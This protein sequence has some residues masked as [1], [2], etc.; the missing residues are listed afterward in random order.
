MANRIAFEVSSPTSA[1]VTETVVPEAYTNFLLGKKLFVERPLLWHEDAPTLFRKAIELDPDFAP[2]HAYLAICLSLFGLPPERL[3][4]VEAANK[5]A[6]ELASQLAETVFAK[7]LLV[8][9]RDS[10]TQAS[11]ALMRQAIVLDPTLSAAYNILGIELKREGQIAEAHRVH[12]TALNRDPLNPVLITN[13]AWH[14][15]DRGEFDR[16]ERMMMRMTL[17]PEE[18]QF[19]HRHVKTMYHQ[20]GRYDEYIRWS[21]DEVRKAIQRDWK[22]EHRERVPGRLFNV[23]GAHAYAYR[24]IGLRETGLQL[25]ERVAEDHPAHDRRIVWKAELCLAQ[26]NFDC[27]VKLQEGLRN[28]L[29]SDAPSWLSTSIGFAYFFAGDFDRAI[30]NLES[31]LF[32]EEDWQDQLDSSDSFDVVHHLIFALGAQGREKEANQLA[33]EAGSLLDSRMEMMGLRIEPALTQVALSRWLRGDSEGAIE[34]FRSTVDAGWIYLYEARQ[35]PL[36][37]EF[38]QIADFRNELRAVEAEIERQRAVVEAADTT[39]DFSN[40]LDGFLA[41]FDEQT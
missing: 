10:D 15:L 1:E 38:F 36:W 9:W 28:D 7:A 13:V 17:L 5:R 34:A 6:A 35:D 16:G 40:V 8:K 4:E 25:L 26:G 30:E 2:A 14:Y 12:E 23:L 39:D 33:V 22:P 11:I 18:P 37:R 21:K 29:G 41:K 32:A 24:Q 31:G 3:E 20:L 19:F 27:A